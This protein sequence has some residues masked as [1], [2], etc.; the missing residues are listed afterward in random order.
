MQLHGS[1]IEGQCCCTSNEVN[2]LNQRN[3]RMNPIWRQIL[4]ECSTSDACCDETETYFSSSQRK[5]TEQH[6]RVV[7]SHKMLLQQIRHIIG[8]LLQSQT[9]CT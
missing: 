9:A 2:N 1:F 7:K 8:L 3:K 6:G 4:E 5:S